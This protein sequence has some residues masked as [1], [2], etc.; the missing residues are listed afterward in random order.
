MSWSASREPV[1]PAGAPR[2]GRGCRAALAVAL[3]A[4]LHGCGGERLPEVVVENNTIVTS[5]YDFIHEHWREEKLG[6]LFQ[7]ENY[8][9]LTA[10]DELSLFRIA[11][12]WTHRQWK[13]GYPDPYPLCNAIDILRDIRSGKTGGFCG[14]YAYVLADVLKSA[15]FYSVRYV[16]LAREDGAGHF[17]VEAWSDDD[18]KWVVLDP[19]YNV[20]FRLVRSGRPAN[21]GEIRESLFGGEPV[22]AVPAGAA[23]AVDTAALVPTYRNFAVSL[24]SDLMR[25]PRPLGNLDRLDMFLFYRDA[26]TGKPY[27]KGIPYRSVTSRIEDVYYDRN[28][29]RVETELHP[30][31]VVLSFLTDAS[32]ANFM[33][34]RVRR[35]P[36]GS[37]STAPQ[38]LTVP[39]AA[40]VTT[41]W[42]AATNR[43]GRLGVPNRVD[44]RWQ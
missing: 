29:T 11:C 20:T 44:I 3:A 26:R 43:F 19:Y 17:V 37:W 35:E 27:E 30:D 31:R 21:A 41:L 34:F 23:A 36:A 33:E 6:Q 24:R 22:E 5:N 8:K 15:G 4:C 16:E 9:D 1:P 7:Q 14:Q 13:E 40:G 32:M 28:R 18:R 12:D 2:P 39:R 38:R 42:V 10:G 25:H